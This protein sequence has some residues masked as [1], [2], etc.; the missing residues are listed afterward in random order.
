MMSFNHFYDSVI[1]ISFLN[2][3]SFWPDHFV[4][5]QVEAK[6][7]KAEEGVDILIALGHAGYGLDMNMAAEI[8]EIDAVVGGHSHTFLWSGKCS[9][10]F[11]HREVRPTKK[12]SMN[13]SNLQR[14]QSYKTFRRLFRH[15]AQ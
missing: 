13:V 1:T 14:V 4:S 8:E 6:R 2:F 3:N 5:V 10:P 12:G 15:L 9:W 11:L 7:L